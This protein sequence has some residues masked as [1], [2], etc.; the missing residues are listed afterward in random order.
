MH[1]LRKLETRNPELHLR[2]RDLQRP[3][4]HPSF[5]IVAGP[6]AEWERA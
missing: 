1:L 6:V 2:W 3:R 4:A 5:R